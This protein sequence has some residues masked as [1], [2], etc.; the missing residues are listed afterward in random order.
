MHSTGHPRE[1]PLRWCRWWHLTQA[2]EYMAARY[3]WLDH[4][5]GISAA[6]DWTRKTENCLKRHAPQSSDEDVAHTAGF[7]E[8]SSCNNAITNIW[9]NWRQWIP[10]RGCESK[11]KRTKA[12]SGCNELE[13]TEWLTKHG[14]CTEE[15]PGVQN[16]V[17]GNITA[18]NLRERLDG[19]GQH[20]RWT[21][22]AVQ[23]W[24]GNLA[25]IRAF[26][27]WNGSPRGWTQNSH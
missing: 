10:S 11:R 14:L 21:H 12:K 22:P 7:K 5:W 3:G 26:Y 17:F 18:E 15:P 6:T 8:V 20:E 24:V 2:T 16:H 27:L 4:L 13:Q 9:M 19:T 1:L 23:D 25:T